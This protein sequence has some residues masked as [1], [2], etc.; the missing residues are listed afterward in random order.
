MIE[1]LFAADLGYLQ[2][3]YRRIN[4]DGTPAAAVTCPHCERPFEVETEPRWGND[5][6]PLGRDCTRR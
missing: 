5:G 3:L 4:D 6:L 2:D 1:G